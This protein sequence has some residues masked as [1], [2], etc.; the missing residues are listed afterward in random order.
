M[1][2][3]FQRKPDESIRSW[4]ADV[5]GGWSMD[6]QS[7]GTDGDPTETPGG[8]QAHQVGNDPLGHDDGDPEKP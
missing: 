3:Y 7:A 4:D 6:G 5:G 1:P 8:D 2:A